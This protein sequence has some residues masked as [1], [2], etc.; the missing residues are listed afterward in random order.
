MLAKTDSRLELGG[1]NGEKRRLTESD[2]L[3]ALFDD[4][5]SSLDLDSID[6]LAHA[7]KVLLVAAGTLG[8]VVQAGTSARG[9]VFLA[10]G[11]D[12][13][14]KGSEGNSVLHFDWFGVVERLW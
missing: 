9:D 2:I 5:R 4:A 12:E 14:E 11:S 10:L 1:H 3:T 8:G 13:G 6:L 7:G